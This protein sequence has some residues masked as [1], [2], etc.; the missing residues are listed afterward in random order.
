MDKAE[1]AHLVAI[2]AAGNSYN[3]KPD[4]S[5]FYSVNLEVNKNKK[6]KMY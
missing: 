3:L 2:W 4:E 1:K 5:A 6:I